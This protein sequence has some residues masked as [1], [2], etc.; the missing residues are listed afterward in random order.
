MIIVSGANGKLGRA[1]V[2]RLLDRVAPERVGVCVRD[3]ERAGEL[4]ERG[5]RV[6]WGDF[7]DA[8][9]LEHAFEAASRVLLVSVDAI[10]ETAL[11]LH[12]TAIDVAGK[13]GAERIVYTSHMGSNPSSLFAPMLDHAAT[14]AALERS[15]IRFTSLRNG[16]YATSALMLLGT[17]LQTG[18]LA[19]PQDGPVS[20]TA[21]SDLAEA[22]AIALTEDVLDGTTPAL[23]GAE[24]I[25]MTG[26]AALAS[27]LTGRSIRRV[28][29]PD[30]EFRAGLVAHGVPEAAADLLVGMFAASHQGEFAQVDPALA[31]LIG[32]PPVPLRAI[33]EP[34]I[35]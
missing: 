18:E 15:G 32:R 16:F 28:V 11:R 14:E 23:T 5:V 2:E 8:S 25:D 3:P 30:D 4:A 7:A 26:V 22:A 29:V 33:L 17:A 12:Q 27:E 19:V 10:G 21:H 34:A 13:A 6:R 20:W 9:S 35:P 24:A 31:R 1:V